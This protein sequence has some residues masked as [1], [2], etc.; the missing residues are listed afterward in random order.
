VTVTIRSEAPDDRAAVRLV[1]DAA[2]A[3][4]GRVADLVAALEESG[5]TRASLVAVEDGEIVGHVGLSR[6]WVDAARRLVEVLVLSPLSVAPER[7][8]QGI[9]TLLVRTAL[10]E[11]ERLGAP[12]VFLEGDP[13]YYAT[14]GFTPADQRGFGRPSER[15]PWPAF[16]VALLSAY[17][18]WMSG[19]LVYCDPFWVLDCVGLRGATLAD[20]RARLGE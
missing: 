15:I 19:R 13:G 11:G 4:G 6:S 16:Q 2:F 7:Q 12:A 1:V 10:E 5:H 17:R 14:R 8:G 18:P 9:G 20:V 3:D